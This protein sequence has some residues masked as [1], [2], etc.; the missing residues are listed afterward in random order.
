MKQTIVK[1]VDSI[2][3]TIEYVLT[4]KNLIGEVTMVQK[5]LISYELQK[6]VI[7][8]EKYIN[9]LNY[10]STRRMAIFDVLYMDKVEDYCR[11]LDESDNLVTTYTRLTTVPWRTY[12]R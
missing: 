5:L 1:T 12:L 10:D 3:N 6:V 9:G 8:T 4:E 7:E 11:R 2:K